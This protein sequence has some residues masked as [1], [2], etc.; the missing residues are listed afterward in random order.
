MKCLLYIPTGEYINFSIS[1]INKYL[2]IDIALKHNRTF[3][4]A[5]LLSSFIKEFVIYLNENKFS[6]RFVSIN[7]LQIPAIEEDFDIINV[8]IPNKEFNDYDS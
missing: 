2:D 3:A 4:N 5:V 7:N 1:S 6:D 8:N